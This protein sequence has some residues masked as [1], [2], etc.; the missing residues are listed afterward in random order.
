VDPKAGISVVIIAYNEANNIG[1]CIDSVA[2][3]ASEVLVV[4]SFSTDNTT[5]IAASKG[6][7]VIQHAFEGHIQQKNWAKDQA[8][9]DW[10]LSLDA[11]ECLS[12]TLSENLKIAIQHGI[13]YG[14][15]KGYAFSR[16]NHLGQRAIRGCG[17]YPDRKM[18]L[19]DRTSGTWAGKN[20]HDKFV[21]DS[22]YKT[23]SMEG[24]ILH[25]TYPNLDAVKK[26]AIKFGKIGGVALREFWH[27]EASGTVWQRFFGPRQSGMYWIFFVK[28]LTA[29]LSRFV[30]NY[31]IKGGWKYGKD[32]LV[33]CFWQM[34]EATLKYAFALFGNNNNNN[35]N[36]NSNNPASPHKSSSPMP[37]TDSVNDG[38]GDQT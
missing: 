28:L 2:D 6:A 34:A 11:D 1:H 15:T 7:R 16:L 38:S 32:G 23:G 12:P 31:F 33:I 18:R 14:I 20:P 30:R 4:D 27:I 37:S 25:Y 9:F 35:N 3:I 29:G 36:S 13:T 24:D 19:W 22:Q 26:Q 10:V 8:T 5:A 21:I 17:W